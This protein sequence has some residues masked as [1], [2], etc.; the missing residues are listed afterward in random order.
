MALGITS[1]TSSTREYYAINWDKTKRTNF[2]I[3][4]VGT[5]SFFIKKVISI[6]SS[7]LLAEIFLD[8]VFF[9]TRTNP[10]L[11]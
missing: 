11:S 9:S 7:F 5:I 3:F 10:L 2:T 1:M 4:T 6:S 8:D